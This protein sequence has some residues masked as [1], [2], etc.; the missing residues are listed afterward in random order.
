MSGNVEFQEFLEAHK[1]RANKST[2]SND[3][4]ISSS[5]EVGKE[6]E[7]K[8]SK[9]QTGDADGS[10]LKKLSVEKEKAEAEVQKADEPKKK[11]SDLEVNFLC[12]LLPF[13]CIKSTISGQR[14][15]SM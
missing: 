5:S 7:A 3:I 13:C 10:L 4:V 9:P 15:N 1:P 11:L 14:S 6:S 2:W 8:N 12:L